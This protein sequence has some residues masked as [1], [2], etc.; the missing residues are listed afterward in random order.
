VRSP[1]E[2]TG[3]EA[4][5]RD[6]RINTGVRV[7]MLAVAWVLTASMA[8]AQDSVADFYRGKTVQVIIPSTVGGSVGLYGRLFTDHIGRHIPG[9]P[10]VTMLSMPGAGG[11]QSVDFV[12]NVAPKDGTV[13]GEI[14]SPAILVPMMQKVRYDPTKLLWLGS[15]TARPGVVGVWHTARATTL[16]GAKKAELVLGSTGVGA[17]NYQIPTMS[18]AIL[19]TRFKVVTGY[20]GGDLINLAIERGELDGRFNYWSAW[21]TTKPDWIRDKKLVFMY[22]TGPKAPDMPDL[23]ALRDLVGGEERLMVDI[24]DAPDNVGVGFYISPEVPSARAAA[25]KT[26]MQA[27]MQDKKFLAEAAR[28]H[29]PIAP[30]P[31]EELQKIVADIFSAPPALIERFK[32]T[33]AA[34][35]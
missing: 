1:E 16:D 23:P 28:L 30:V 14:L 13:I 17:G 27:M 21:T 31:G 25:L 26:A 3:E 34:K 5:L 11:I 15:L 29:A 22:R 10:T 6:H 2:K 24:L 32:Q 35:K 18:N 19:G 33:I 20:A 9:H 7:A 4:M 12:A 8:A